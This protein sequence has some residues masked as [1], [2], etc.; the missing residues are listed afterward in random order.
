M[1]ATATIVTRTA[2]TLMATAT[3]IRRVIENGSRKRLTSA[4][5]AMKPRIIVIHVTVAAAGRLPSS[6]RRA[7]STR[8][9]VP[10]APTPMPMAVNE[11]DRGAK[12]E[13]EG[14]REQ[15]HRAGSANYRL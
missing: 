11:N 7:I 5:V 13:R 14:C 10:L 8:S 3:S 2:A 6:T 1:P 4:A 12:A 15:R 9:D